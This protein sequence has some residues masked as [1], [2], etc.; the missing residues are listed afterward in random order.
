MVRFA[1]DEDV[2]GDEGVVVEEKGLEKGLRGTE[3]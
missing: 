3:R 1:A 2:A